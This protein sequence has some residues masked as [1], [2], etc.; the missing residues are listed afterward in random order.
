MQKNTSTTKMRMRVYVELGA[1]EQQASKRQNK[2][3]ETIH[4][5]KS[6]PE[7]ETRNI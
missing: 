7:A 5:K 6:L 1:V 4:R 2:K 3:N